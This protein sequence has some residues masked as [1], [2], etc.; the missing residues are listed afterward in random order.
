LIRISDALLKV[1]DLIDR[2]EGAKIISN[3][4]LNATRVSAKVE[5]SYQK[6]HKLAG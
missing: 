3:P 4:E 5:I 2:Y 6:D 1:K